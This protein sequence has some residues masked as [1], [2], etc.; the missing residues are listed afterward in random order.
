MATRNGYDRKG[1]KYQMEQQEQQFAGLDQSKENEGR[2][3]SEKEQVK[4]TET[5]YDARYYRTNEPRHRVP[6]QDD[7]DFFISQ[8]KT[9]T[10]ALSVPLSSLRTPFERDDR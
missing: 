3:F 5:Y 1:F 10:V 9:M 4:Q 7:K 6:N 8:V 2:K